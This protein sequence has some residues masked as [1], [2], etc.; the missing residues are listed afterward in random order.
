MI[1][2]YVN[3]ALNTVPKYSCTY[4]RLSVWSVTDSAVA[5]VVGVVG[6]D[7]YRAK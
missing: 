1:W 5:P 4:E 3:M 6:R 2:K 7:A